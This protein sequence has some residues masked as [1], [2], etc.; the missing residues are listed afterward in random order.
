MYVCALSGRGESSLS[1]SNKDWTP[2]QPSAQGL[3]LYLQSIQCTADQEKKQIG[4][5]PWVGGPIFVPSELTSDQAKKLVGPP[6]G[7]YG[8]QKCA[9]IALPRLTIH[10]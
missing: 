10:L 4:R 7:D 8:P 2:L 1:P 6:P 3:V 5:T 9:E